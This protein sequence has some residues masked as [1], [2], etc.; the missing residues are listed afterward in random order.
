[1]KKQ[2]I[3]ALALI[4]LLLVSCDSGSSCSS[5]LIYHPEYHEYYGLYGVGTNLYAWQD[6]SEWYFGFTIG[7]SGISDSLHEIIVLQ[8]NPCPL[9]ITKDILKTYYAVDPNY[10]ISLIVVS[11]PPK[12]EELNNH[13]GKDSEYA[14]LYDS[15]DITPRWET[16]V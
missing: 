7:R 12:E 6:D 9:D 16:N 10:L 15:L 3:L 2:V 4:P 5:C 1:M 8:A 11:N 14:Y 13:V